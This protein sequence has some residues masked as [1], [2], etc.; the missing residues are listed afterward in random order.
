MKR[1]SGKQRVGEC[2]YCGKEAALTRDHIPPKGLFPEP[3][4]HD[5]IAVDCCFECNNLASKDDEYF[6]LTISLRHDVCKAQSGSVAESAIKALGRPQQRWFTKAFLSTVRKVNVYSEGGIYLWDSGTYNVDLNRL[7][8]VATRVVQGL[9]YHHFGKILRAPC[10]AEA[11]CTEG[12][13]RQTQTEEVK[14]I[15]HLIS[16]LQYLEPI[17]KADGVFKY[18][19]K[20]IGEPEDCSSYWYMCFYERV[21][22]FAITENGSSLGS[23]E[24]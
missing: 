13:P 17:V 4:P 2:I 16:E 10:S 12:F 14:L 19:F 8:K 15:R 3:R 11:W 9:Y 20:Q 6:R 5:L 23:G 18:W 1:K 21:G 24:Y 22:F 7:N